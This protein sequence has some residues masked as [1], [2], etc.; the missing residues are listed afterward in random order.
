M[1]WR[2]AR[3]T[4]SAIRQLQPSQTLRE[5]GIEAEG[6]ADGSIRYS[7]EFMKDGKR[8]HRRL[9]RDRDGMNLRQAELFI[10]QH[11]SNLRHGRLSLP[12]GRKLPQTAGAL[13]DLYLEKLREVGGADFRNNEQHIRLHLRPY[14]GGMRVDRI[15]DFTMQKFQAHC[16]EAGLTKAT[17]N[18]ILATWRRASRRLVA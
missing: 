14:F 7:V 12:A 17:C 3:L 16:R 6:L 10:E 9:G 5:H 1:P 11:R 13:L 18:R 8:E 15:S 4:Q 2:F